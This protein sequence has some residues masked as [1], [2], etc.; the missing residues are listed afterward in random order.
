MVKES[1]KARRERQLLTH[2]QFVKDLKKNVQ[3]MWARKV[4]ID[5]KHFNYE[6]VVVS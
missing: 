2:Q 4:K 6:D 5:D 3:E 1:K